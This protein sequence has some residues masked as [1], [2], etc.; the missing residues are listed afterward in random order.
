MK[1]ITYNIL[2]GFENAAGRKKDCATWLKQQAPDILF[3]NELNGFTPQSLA[4]YAKEWDHPYSFLLTG[5]SD[6]K[7]AI[8]AKFPLTNIQAFYKDLLGH[9]IITCDCIGISLITT[10]LNP[11]SIKKR[12]H[13]LDFIIRKI[14][15][16][17]ENK[18][19]FVFGG[20]LNSFFIGEKKYYQDDLNHLRRWYMI[21]TKKNPAFENLNNDQFDFSISE[22]LLKLSLVDLISKH[23]KEYHLSYL[24]K[25]GK[26]KLLAEDGFAE[27]KLSA[28]LMHAR[29]DYLWANPNLA[30]LCLSCEIPQEPELENISDHLPVVAIFCEH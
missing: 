23:T 16:L 6:Y 27:S 26:E 11:H 4:L 3:L 15:T 20:D 2:D 10:H 22:R 19:N 8:T 30:S 25:L 7:I 1:I 29:I 24:S 9:G 17:L 21:R 13:D 12:H 18:K 28:S 5:R 14:E